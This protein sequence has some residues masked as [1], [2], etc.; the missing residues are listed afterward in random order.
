[1]NPPIYDFRPFD[2]CRVEQ[3]R[4][5]RAEAWLAEAMGKTKKTS[6]PKASAPK[7]PA[8]ISNLDPALQA[9][10]MAALKKL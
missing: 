7:I 1:M 3:V 6:S 10:I 2:I 5:L 4:R 8:A 9:Q